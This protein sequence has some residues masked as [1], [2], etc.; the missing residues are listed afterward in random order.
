MGT[1]TPRPQVLLVYFSRAG[2]NYWEGGRRDLEVGNT[3]RLATMIAG[4]TGCDVYRIEASDPY[5]D[6]YDDTV[7]R[8]VREQDTNARP[9][10]AG[11]LPNIS[12]YDVVILASPIWNVRPPMIM[13]T[14]AES[15]PLGDT[16]VL[17]VTTHA[18]SGLGRSVEVY[19]DLAPDA[20]I[21]EGLAV[22]GEDV[23]DAGPELDRW[24]SSV[25]L[26]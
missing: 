13:S 7:A 4:R 9:G 12:T 23:D 25:E 15:V 19:S 3:E 24:L 26:V 14:F 8:N 2:E 18:M 22:R 16:T 1:S 6:D 17:P 10:I 11:E 20:T 5:S 21:G